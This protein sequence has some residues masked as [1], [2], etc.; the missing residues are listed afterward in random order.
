MDRRIKSTIDK[1]IIWSN[2]SAYLKIISQESSR[3]TPQIIWSP[4][5]LFSP[6]TNFTSKCHRPK[7]VLPWLQS[8]PSLQ[9]P[10]LQLLDLQIRF[11]FRL[12]IHVLPWSEPIQAGK[13]G[14]KRKR[15][16]K[17]LLLLL[18]ISIIIVLKVSSLS[19]REVMWD[20]RMRMWTQ[21]HPCKTCVLFWFRK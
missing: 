13:D 21:H 3:N 14:I 2:S 12:T 10:S 1:V 7:S 4:A 19:P 8:Q 9:H 5:V 11:C 17:Y 20:G 6:G 18:L 15:W 16:K